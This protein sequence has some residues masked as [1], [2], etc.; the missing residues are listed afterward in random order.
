MSRAADG[1]TELQTAAAAIN[2]QA[3]DEVNLIIATHGPMG[4]PV[5]VGVV[6]GLARRQV[7]L[8]AKAAAEGGGRVVGR[9][10]W[11]ADDS[12]RHGGVRGR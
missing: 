6:A 1:Y 10:G 9:G 11:R 2:P 8:E 12:N 3:V 7:P 5:A 4:Y